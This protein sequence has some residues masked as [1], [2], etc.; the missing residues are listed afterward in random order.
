MID[1]VLPTMS[2]ITMRTTSKGEFIATSLASRILSAQRPIVAWTYAASFNWRRIALQ[3][4]SQ[5]VPC[6]DQLKVPLEPKLWRC[7]QAVTTT[8]AIAGVVA[9][10]AIRGSGFDSYHADYVS[11][12]A[13]NCAIVFGSNDNNY[14]D[15]VLSSLGVMLDNCCL[16]YVP[17]ALANACS[18]SSA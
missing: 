18:A 7:V 15:P 16:L 8:S 14:L 10:L 3:I 4:C 17:S 2:T 6:P 13:G 12:T 1:R 11:I 9:E 5:L